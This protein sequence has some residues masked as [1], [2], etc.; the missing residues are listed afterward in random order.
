MANLDTSVAEFCREFGIWPV[1]LYRS[2]D[3]N[4][5]QREHGKRVVVL[6]LKNGSVT[7]LTKGRGGLGQ[8]LLSLDLRRK[9]DSCDKIPLRSH[10]R[11]FR[12]H[13]QALIAGETVPGNVIRR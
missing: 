11:T 4:G 6:R 10:F 2:I 13:S 9:S 1:T 5:G 7:N 3:P 8:A 12:G